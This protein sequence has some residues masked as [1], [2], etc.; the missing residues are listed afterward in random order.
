MN[1]AQAIEN[2]IDKLPHDPTG[3]DDILNPCIKL[4]QDALGQ[5]YGDA[6]S[7]YFSGMEWFGEWCKATTREERKQIVFKY[8]IYELNQ[9]PINITDE[10]WAVTQNGYFFKIE[11]DI[12][13]TLFDGRLFKCRTAALI[14][15]TSI[16]GD[17]G[18]EHLKDNHWRI[19]SDKVVLDDRGCSD[20]KVLK[21]VETYLND[22]EM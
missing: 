8:V 7:I 17:E 15:V 5:P 10:Q 22:F 12:E 11:C 13:P 3:H 14:Q 16:V 21:H 6:A 18:A 20:G 4:I 1:L 19:T 9:L 2:F